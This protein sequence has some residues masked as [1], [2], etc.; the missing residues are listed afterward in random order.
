M[1]LSLLN[2]DRRFIRE[3]HNGLECTVFSKICEVSAVCRH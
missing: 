1:R 3:N 2:R